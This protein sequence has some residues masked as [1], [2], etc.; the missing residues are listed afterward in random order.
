MLNRSLTAAQYLQESSKGTKFIWEELPMPG[1]FGDELYSKA[2]PLGFAHNPSNGHSEELLD[3]EFIDSDPEQRSIVDKWLSGETVYRGQQPLLLIATPRDPKGPSTISVY[4]QERHIGWIVGSDSHSL[5]EHLVANFDF[6]AAVFETFSF[7][8][9]NGRIDPQILK[10]LLENKEEVVRI[11][12]ITSKAL[13]S[14]EKLEW[15]FEPS[16]IHLRSGEAWDEEFMTKV[17]V[18]NPEIIES[19]G[20]PELEGIMEAAYSSFVPNI[21]DQRSREVFVFIDEIYIGKICDSDLANAFFEKL[22]NPGHSVGL[23][24]RM[25]VNRDDS[26]IIES[27]EIPMIIR[28]IHRI[29]WE[30]VGQELGV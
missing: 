19:S 17:C 8:P 4:E 22:T 26:G 27:L 6:G 2:E 24:K 21:W 7:Q 28:D 13:V 15:D 23:G 5:A 18:E 16:F 14:P 25:W 29:D 3:L 12:H 10:A 1:P 30:S 20:L 9:R 11:S